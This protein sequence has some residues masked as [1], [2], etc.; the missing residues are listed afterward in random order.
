ME[1]LTPT[2]S[3]NIFLGNYFTSF[4][5]FTYIGINNIQVT[6]VLKQNWLNK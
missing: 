4:R 2:V 1:C 3:F 6:G 5:L